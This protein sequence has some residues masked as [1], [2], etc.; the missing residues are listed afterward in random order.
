MKTIMA[1]SSNCQIWS[2]VETAPCT[3]IPVEYDC[4]TVKKVQELFLM[5]SF[6]LKS[7]FLHIQ[8]LQFK[9]VRII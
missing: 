6:F 8:A 9:I 2:P 7:L 1:E 3:G 5:E 4:K